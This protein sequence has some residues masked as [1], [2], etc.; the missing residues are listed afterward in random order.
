MQPRRCTLRAARERVP[1]N[2]T[3]SSATP[4]STGSRCGARGCARAWVRGGGVRVIRMRR[5][6]SLAH[7]TL[8]Q[9]TAVD[10]CWRRLLALRN[11]KEPATSSAWLYLLTRRVGHVASQRLIS[12]AVKGYRHF[13]R[14]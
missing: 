12:L 9:A 7:A 4:C 11:M 8:R 5:R 6:C 10:P 1:P 14:G 13:S 3:V 2:V